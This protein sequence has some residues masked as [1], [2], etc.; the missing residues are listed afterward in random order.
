MFGLFFKSESKRIEEL[1][2]RVKELEEGLGI[3]I[4]L[5]KAQSEALMSLTSEVVKLSEALKVLVSE[6]GSTAR[7]SKSGD[8]FH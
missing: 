3:T 4:R 7:K 5:M 2:K 6:K 8:Y 1:E